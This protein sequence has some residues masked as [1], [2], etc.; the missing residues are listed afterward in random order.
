MKSMLA[1]NKIDNVL[2]KM[3]IEPNVEHTISNKRK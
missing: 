3:K 1:R 2:Y